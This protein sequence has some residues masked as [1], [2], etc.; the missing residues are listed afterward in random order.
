[1]KR[2]RSEHDLLQNDAEAVDVT[3]ERGGGSGV[4]AGRNQL[5]R[6]PE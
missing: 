3:L 1:M 2:P 6:G 5:R 4:D